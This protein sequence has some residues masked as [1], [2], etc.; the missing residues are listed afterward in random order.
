MLSSAAGRSWCEYKGEASYLSLTAGGVTADRAAW[1]YPSPTRGFEVL[2][3]K[4]AV[5]PSRMDRI[6]VDGITVEAQEGDFYGGWITR[7]WS[8]RSRARRAR[9]AGDPGGRLR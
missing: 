9:S 5:Y 7:A 1:W 2:A 4:V 3:D 8:A 6:T